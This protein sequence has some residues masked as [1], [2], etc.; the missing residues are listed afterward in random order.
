MELFRER[1]GVTELP[2]AL[3]R[4]VI[5]KS[6][7][8]PLFAEEIANYLVEAGSLHADGEEVSYDPDAG[9]TVLPVTL[10]NLL[11]DRFDRLAEGPRAALEAASVIGPRFSADLVSI[12][13]GPD[14][15]AAGH[16]VELERLELIRR[17]PERG[18]YRFKHALVRDAIYDSLLTARREA[19]HE[20]AAETLENRH[21]DYRDEVADVLA[22]HWDQAGR[23]DKAVEFLALAGGNSLRVYALDEAEQRFRRA[24]EL[25][26]ADPEAADDAALTDILLHL[27]RILYFQYSYFA[28]IELVDNY[29]PRVEAL[30]DK[31][32]LSRFLFEGGYAHI[33]AAQAEP[34]QD[35]L[36][37]ARALG[38]ESGDDLAVAYAELG[39]MWHRLNWGTPGEER[40]KIQRE[41][42]ERVVDTGKRHGDIWLTSKALLCLGLG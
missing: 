11:M 17:E 14:G 12:V 15:N 22:H 16:L 30:G 24:L 28:I 5:E 27:A 36:H 29:L 8:N 37:R 32:R 41:A 21:T 35:L 7:G 4:V 26:G 13:T 33:F 9:D 18:D 2:E 39:L 1:L 25:I 40:R 38:E 19:L 20:R 31:K 3:T 6:E 10:E 34:G 42:G 23:A